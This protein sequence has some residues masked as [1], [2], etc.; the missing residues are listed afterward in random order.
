MLD[1]SCGHG[2]HDK[3]QSDGLNASN[4]SVEFDGKQ[5][6]LRESLIA[7][8]DGYL[9]P[10]KRKLGRQGRFLWDHSEGILPAFFNV[11]LQRFH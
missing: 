6:A 2:G 1:H 8:E 7:E 3:Q 11:E 5:K 10:Y 4:M 9:G